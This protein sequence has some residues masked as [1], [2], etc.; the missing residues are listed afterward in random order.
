MQTSL[1]TFLQVT[2]CD[3]SISEIISNLMNEDR[4]AILN[5]LD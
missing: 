5:C 1:K 3:A 4:G 2:Q